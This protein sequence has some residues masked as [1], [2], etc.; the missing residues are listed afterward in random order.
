M[1]VNNSTLKSLDWPEI[2][3]WMISFR[4]TEG[5][6]ERFRE[7]KFSSHAGEIKLRQSETL[8]GR[9]LNEVDPSFRPRVGLNRI[10]DPADHLTLLQ[11]GG[12]LGPGALMEIKWVA[13]CNQQIK[14]LFS[15]ADAFSGS[16]SETGLEA[17]ALEPIR[18]LVRTLPN[19]SE[20]VKT[21]Q[22]SIEEWSEEDL[23]V[24]EERVPA[25]VKDSASS[26][27]ANLRQKARQLKKEIE[28]KTKKAME[29]AQRDGYL[30]DNWSDQRDGHHIIPIK[31]EFQKSLKGKV[32]DKSNTGATVYLEPE[33]IQETSTQWKQIE[34]AIHLEVQ[35]VLKKISRSIQPEA[36]A[37]EDSYKKIV[38]LDFW[39]ARGAFSK[40]IKGETPIEISDKPSI[41]LKDFCHPLL[42]KGLEEDKVVKNSLHLD[43]NTHGIVISGP[44]TGGKTV[45][46]KSVGVCQL[47]FAAGL[48]VPAHKSSKLFPFKTL[49]CDLGDSQSIENHLSSFSGRLL[50]AEEMLSHS[51]RDSLILIDEILAAT[52]PEEAS[53]LAQA[54]LEQLSRKE[55][56]TILTT[57]FEKLKK[58]ASESR[59]FM[60]SSMEFNQ[61][62][63]SPTYRYREGIPGT[64]QAL[65]IAEKLNL[66][67]ELVSRARSLLGENRVRFEDAQLALQERELE[68]QEKKEKLSEE[69]KDLENRK[70]NI[71]KVTNEL[72]LNRQKLLEKE[73][74]RIRN[75]YSS[76]EDKIEKLL[77]KKPTKGN[78]KKLGQAK[79]ESLRAI[80]R[81]EERRKDP[82]AP[83]EYLEI[84]GWDQIKSGESLYHLGFG[85]KVIYQAGPNS[86]N[87]VEIL[88]GSLKSKA[89][90]EELRIHQ[91]SMAQEKS[92]KD[93][94]LAKNN[95]RNQAAFHYEQKDLPMDCDVRGESLE[96]ALSICRHHLDLAHQEGREWIRIIHGHGEGVLKNGI[97]EWLNTEKEV[98]DFQPE[99]PLEGGDGVTR[100]VLR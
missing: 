99:H 79:R 76:A 64:S 90:P 71:K 26:K 44:N 56:K 43:E 1:Q 4:M 92:S 40:E 17:P 18:D 30:Q 39:I 68:L 63:L 88:V 31:D 19:L 47:L 11:K 81:R 73:K 91:S 84:Q 23:E 21:I 15:G 80:D 96:D 60:N 25:R 75:L 46:M 74:Q 58:F 85:K 94:R 87:E 95:Q 48:Q 33:D 70:A 10:K 45:L 49:W 52:D 29:R 2:L 62:E 89:H 27:L 59:N 55:A 67:P 41:F 66:A 78:Q 38:E 93:R 32:L 9:T 37:L 20:I 77:S 14:S 50:S 69:I 13:D 24:S 35:R 34:E 3:N 65:S 36:K 72:K 6:E 54:M 42:I 97:R 22:R 12:V 100:V 16:L 61:K 8:A 98:S 7:M 86:K 83:R 53:A 28:K 57:H 82:Q 5:A 51:N